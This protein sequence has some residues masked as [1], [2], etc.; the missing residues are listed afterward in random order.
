MFDAIGEP[1]NYE[2]IERSRWTP[3]AMVASKWRNRNVFLVGDAAHLWVPMG[4]FGMNAGIADAISLSFRLAGVLQGW[5]HDELLDTYQTERAPIGAAIASQAVTWAIRN[6]TLTA[7]TRERLIELESAQDAR[8]ALGEQLHADML[9][10]FECTGFQLGYFYADSPVIC[11]DTLTPAPTFSVERYIETSWPGVR[12]PH[13]WLADGSS[14]YDHLGLGFSLLRVRDG[15]QFGDAIVEEAAARAVPLTVVELDPND[16][17]QAYDGFELLLVRPDQHVV[18]R[19]HTD[20]SPD[21]ARQMRLGR[22]SA[23][24]PGTSRAPWQRRLRAPCSMPS[25]DR[26]LRAR[27]PRPPECGRA[28]CEAWSGGG[29]SCSRIAAATPRGLAQNPTSVTR[30]RAFFAHCAATI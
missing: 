27:G 3:R 17:G 2:I 30:R 7:A 8:R 14:I 16:A 26:A 9:S 25:T 6:A 1:F 10:E 22:S 15:G 12:L 21:E 28:A 11:H 5:A 4:G 13:R 19:S 29:R 20:P 23:A 18:W 24:A